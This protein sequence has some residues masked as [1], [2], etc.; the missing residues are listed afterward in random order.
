[1]ASNL[2]FYD[3]FVPQK[4]PLSKISDDVI[5]CDFWFG[6]PP[7]KNPGYAYAREEGH[8]GLCSPQITACTP[9]ARVN[10][11]VSTRGPANFCPNT[12][13]YKPFF[14][15]K[16]Q[17]RSSERNQVAQDFAMKRFLYFFGLDVQI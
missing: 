2:P 14:S 8:F 11:C 17:H 16:Q 4:V 1:M 9:Q 5:A 3:I 6:P 13:H 10:F 7:I 15:T 12:G